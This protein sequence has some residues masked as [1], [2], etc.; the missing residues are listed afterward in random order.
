MNIPDKLV[1]YCHGFGSSSNTSKLKELQDAGFEAYCFDASLDPEIAIESLTDK[2]DN[3]LIDKVAGN[4]SM[5]VVGT[6]LGGWYA[7]KIA[8]MYDCN[9]VVINPSYD[10]ST[11]LKKYGVDESLL[12]K[13]SKLEVNSK[14]KYYFAEED[15]IIDHTKCIQECKDKNVD[16]VIVP[17]ADHRFNKDFNLV[18][19]YL[20]K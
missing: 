16:Y 13:Y 3:L 14:H 17:G 5:T 4:T 9:A 6:S 1:I 10:P 19:D 11:S 2:I 20:K 15:S 7:S 18:I 12:S 8:S